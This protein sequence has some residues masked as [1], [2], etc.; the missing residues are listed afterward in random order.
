MSKKVICDTCGDDIKYCIPK[1][2]EENLHEEEHTNIGKEDHCLC[3]GTEFCI[4]D[5]LD[6]NLTGLENVYRDDNEIV[7]LELI[8]DIPKKYMIGKRP[9][10]RLLGWGEQTFSRY[11]DGDVPSKQYSD[12]LYKIYKDPG[13][14]AEILEKNKGKLKTKSSY[15]KSKEAVDRLLGKDDNCKIQLV[16][17]YILNKCED[18][19][20]LAVQKALYYV[21]GIY[22][23]FYGDYIFKADCLAGSYGPVYPEV[24]KKY[25]Y[26]RFYP[27]ESRCIFNDALLSTTEK[28][29]LDAVIKGVCC[30]SGSVLKKITCLEEPWVVE[31]NGLSTVVDSERI[32]EK[33]R[34][35][36]YFT[37]VKEVYGMLTPLDFR[38]YMKDM[39]N[40]VD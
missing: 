9:L 20:P 36:E 5:V 15:K 8:R 25:R 29:V 40:K 34:I 39:F 10:S 13:Y 14:Y 30:Y 38:D 27:R 32:I 31:R 16:T 21:Q 4:G 22:Y 24:Y 18:I 19:T 2:E 3:C 1:K 33:D 26:Y 17:E 35:G 11:Y 6:Y 23:S 37:N 12:V 28:V 7:S